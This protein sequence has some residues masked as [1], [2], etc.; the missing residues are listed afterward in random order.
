MATEVLS[1]LLGTEEYLIPHVQG[2]TTTSYR[3]KNEAKTLIVALMRGGESMAMG[4][5]EALPWA[6][7]LHAKPSED[8]T[9]DYLQGISV[10]LLVDSV[11]NYGS[12]MTEFVNHVH[13]LSDDTTRIVMLAGVVQFESMKSLETLKQQLGR[14]KVSLVALRSSDN[15]YTGQGGTDTGHRLFNT[16]HL[17]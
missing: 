3:V 9:L 10:V 2:H 17:R 13:A 7:F 14:R 11:T 4:V 15:K 12:T 8:V 6:R 5:N 16:T 1:G